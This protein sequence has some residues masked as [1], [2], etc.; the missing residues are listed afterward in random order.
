M[1]CERTIL[2]FERLCPGV[3]HAYQKARAAG[4]P[5]LTIIAWI[6]ANGPAI[7]AKIEEL[8]ALFQQVHQ[9]TPATT[10]TAAN[11]LMSVWPPAK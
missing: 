11:A 2:A 8:I 1:H 9:V 10:P 7:L 5:A 4:V 6:I 3:G